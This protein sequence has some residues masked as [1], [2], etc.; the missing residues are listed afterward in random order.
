MSWEFMGYMAKNVILAVSENGLHTHSGLTIDI[1]N[2][3]M[4][5]ESS[6]NFVLFQAQT[7]LL[8]PPVITHGNGTCTVPFISIGGFSS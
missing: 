4:I 2:V 3:V 1:W 8:Y 5:R 6:L 7:H